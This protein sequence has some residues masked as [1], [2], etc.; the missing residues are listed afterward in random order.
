MLHSSCK[1]LVFPAL[2]LLS[3]P[4]LASE[5]AADLKARR[6]RLMDALGPRAILLIQSAPAKTYSLDIDYE[7]R[8]DSN[9]YYLTGLDQPASTLLLMPGNTARRELL[10]VREKD[11][12]QE[13]WTGR[14]LTTAQVAE[15]SGVETVYL[16]SELPKFLESVL[17]GLPYIKERLDPRPPDFDVFLKAVTAG[18]A[19]LAVV[20][21]SRSR[22]GE[23]VND[24]LAYA[25]RLRD[26][27]PGLSVINATFVVHGLRQVK[28]PYEQRILTQSVEI[29]SKAHLAGMRAARPGAYEYTVKAAIENVYRDS[30]AMGWGYPSITGSGPNATI[31]HYAKDGRR[32]D[33]GDLIL[34]DAAASFQYYTGDITRTYP[35]NGKFSAPQRDIY[36]IVLE[37]QNQAMRMVKPGVL[38]A[39][40][41]AKTIEVIKAGLL[42]VG[43]ITD[44]SGDQYKTWYTHGSVHYLGLDVHDVGDRFV[45]LAPGHAFVIEPGIYIQEDALESLPKTKENLAMIEKVRPAFEKYRGLGVRVEDSFLLTGE[46]LV[47]LSAGV[48]RTIEQIEAFMKARN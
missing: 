22:I 4:L 33:A 30:G 10:F 40:V 25:N 34:V 1:Q 8:Q 36:G 35:V 45:P 24:T 9:F 21:D 48:P 46:G 31:L 29:S 39:E 28:T 16:N 20:S 38:P 7:Y 44:A 37:A 27:F 12:A 11:A 18:E 47:N 23:P 17:A 13:H 42:R 3:A 32:M 6:S 15:Q 2:L 41:H 14:R 26:R 43:L 19:K 5:L